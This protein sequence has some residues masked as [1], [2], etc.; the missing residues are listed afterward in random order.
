[1]IK[2]RMIKKN[3]FF[4][5]FLCFFLL[6]I[7]ITPLEDCLKIVYVFSNEIWRKLELY[8]GIWEIFLISLIFL[9]GILKYVY[10]NFFNSF[11]FPF[12]FLILEM[13]IIE[14]Y[15]QKELFLDKYAV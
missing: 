1:M 10:S 13:F 15:L 11:L 5:I 2:I 6:I 3:F 4:L 14:M 12:I 9:L 8:F 7:I